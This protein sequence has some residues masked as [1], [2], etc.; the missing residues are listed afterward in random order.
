MKHTTIFCLGMIAVMI[1]MTLFLLVGCG[2]TSSRSSPEGITAYAPSDAN[3]AAN[4]SSSVEKVAVTP[5][6]IIYSADITLAT[7]NLASA[8]RDIESK[9]KQCDGYVADSEFGSSADN[10]S[11]KRR[12]GTWKVRVP[13]T[14][15]ETFIKSL[16]GIGNVLNTKV[17][18]QDVSEEFYDVEARLRNKQAE[19]VRL[20]QHL[21]AS[22][23]QLS[24][25]LSVERELS[26]VREEIERIQ[27]R[28]RFLTN[29]TDLTT[30]TITVNEVKN[31]SSSSPRFLSEIGNTLSSSLHSMGDFV[32]GLTLVVIAVLPWLLVSAGIGLPFY[33][34]RRR[35]L[36][37]SS[38]RRKLAELDRTHEQ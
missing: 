10:D 17:S 13:V 32:R 30:V 34:R 15:F 3:S 5:R 6:R 25:I 24:D 4:R 19:E 38:Q 9:V 12:M 28:L 22:T 33:L 35:K 23:A 21:K 16:Q 29:Q 36:A 37:T 2:K 18:S 11:G 27:G 26:R 31:G 8:S 14:Q 7:A 1:S 20:L